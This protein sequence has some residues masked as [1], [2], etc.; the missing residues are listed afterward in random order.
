MDFSLTDDQ[1]ALRDAVRRCCDGEFPAH[2]RGLLEDTDAAARRHATMAALGLTGLTLPAAHGG[3][4][5]GPVE[6]MLAA[7]ELG[8]ALAGAAWLAGSTMAAPLIA[9]AGNAAQQDRWLGAIASGT[10]RATLACEEAHARWDLADLRTTAHTDAEGWELDGSKSGVL[11]GADA[12]LLL[13]LAQ[14]PQ[15]PTLFAVEGNAAGLQRRPYRLID[16]R[17]AAHLQ[18][19]AVR[20]ELVGTVGG[21]GAA[22]ARALD[23]GGAMLVAE[24]VGAAEALLDLTLAHLRQ[25]KQFG[26]PLA[27]FQ[28]LQHRVADHAIAL[29]QLKSMACV[30]ALSLLAESPTARGRGVAAARTL[31]AQLGRRLALD[32]IQLHG[33]MGMTEECAAARYA[34][35]LLA[36]GVLFGDAAFHRQRFAALPSTLDNAGDNA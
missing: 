26:K 7:Q 6:A 18:L 25:R 9:D 1:L 17:Q 30:A 20:A 4:E 31:A 21:G 15:G 27:A 36:N 24:T 29:E 23:H 28:A 34:K 19:S 12:A 35:R 11:D 13:V 32:A 33:A 3:S 5:L 14:A 16:G 2:E 10:L 8:R 22:V